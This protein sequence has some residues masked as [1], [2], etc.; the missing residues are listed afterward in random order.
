MR[1]CGSQDP[2]IMILSVCYEQDHYDN[3]TLARQYL[4]PP[5]QA[6]HGHVLR[7]LSKPPFLKV[8][9][10]PKMRE[11]GKEQNNLVT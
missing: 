2:V 7:T 3:K 5:Q 8:I 10:Y 1:F 6:I 11:E 9:P 4:K